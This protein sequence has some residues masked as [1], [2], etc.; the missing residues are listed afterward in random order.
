M[1][2]LYH[3]ALCGLLV[4]LTG[5]VGPKEGEKKEEPAL[6][7]GQYVLAKEPA[8]AKGVREVRAKAK[9]GAAV[10]VVGRIGGSA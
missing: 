7:A 6:D 4:G 2:R 8:G 9:A 5:C 1:T 10:T 3:V